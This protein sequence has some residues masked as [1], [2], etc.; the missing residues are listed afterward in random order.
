MGEMG[1]SRGSFRGR[2]EGKNTSC[3]FL[4]LG[5]MSAIP[6]RPIERE[7]K[8]LSLLPDCL[9]VG[10]SAHP[11]G[12]AASLPMVA[13]WIG[14]SV[15]EVLQWRVI[16]ASKCLL[17]SSGLYRVR[18]SEGFHFASSGDGIINMVLELPLQVSLVC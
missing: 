15:C 3:P 4:L 17:F 11:I 1:R 7:G 16:R 6:M 14:L 18:L 8:I 2:R 5:F 9:P 13:V 12:V 10:C